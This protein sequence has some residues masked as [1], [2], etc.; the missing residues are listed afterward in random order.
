MLWKSDRE[1]TKTLVWIALAAGTLTFGGCVSNTP[2]PENMARNTQQTAPADL[3]VACANA[4]TQKF[5]ANH[6]SVL[7][8]SSSA[9][10]GGKYQIILEAKGQRSTCL[11]DQTGQVL[12]LE[13]M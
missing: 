5:G 10:D 7:P 4:A 1:Y 2:A 8:V 9:L 12:S 3:Q 13:K 6:A 11:I